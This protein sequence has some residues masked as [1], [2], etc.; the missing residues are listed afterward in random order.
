MVNG[1]FELS[2][3]ARDLGLQR[4]DALTELFDGERIE[5]LARERSDGVVGAAGQAF[6]HIHR[7]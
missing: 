5:I 4:F 2:S 3:D 6:V 1:A 7:G